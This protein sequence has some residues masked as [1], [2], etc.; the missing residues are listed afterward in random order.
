MNLGQILREIA[1]RNSEFTVDGDLVRMG[2]FS[3]LL[4]HADSDED[5]DHVL[6]VMLREMQ[7]WARKTPY[8]ERER[9]SWYRRFSSMNALEIGLKSVATAYLEFLKWKRTRNEPDI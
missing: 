4:H 9:V 3:F 2:G 7:N 8:S 6:M 5:A 1:A